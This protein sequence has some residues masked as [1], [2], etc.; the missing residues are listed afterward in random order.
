[1]KI[2]IIR[3]N[4]YGII[5]TFCTLYLVLRNIEKL[6]LRN[7]EFITHLIMHCNN[8]CAQQFAARAIQLVRKSPF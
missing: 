8:Y 3:S 7:I 6:I 1:M 4:L 5:Q 2:L